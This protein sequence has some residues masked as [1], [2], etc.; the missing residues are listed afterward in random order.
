M[1]I[2][3]ETCVSGRC[4]AVTVISSELPAAAA[5]EAAAG[6]CVAAVAEGGATPWPGTCGAPGVGA[7]GVAAPDEA[8]PHAPETRQRLQLPNT[9]PIRR[10]RRE[11]LI[12]SVVPPNASTR[13]AQSLVA[14]TGIASSKVGHLFPTAWYVPAK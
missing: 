12:M 5:L 6:A 14:K 11:N 4:R 3:T 13:H 10:W 7:E 8:W 1:D 2:G 9:V